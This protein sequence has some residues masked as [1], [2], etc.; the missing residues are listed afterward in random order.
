M[1]KLTIQR[2]T[3]TNSIPLHSTIEAASRFFNRLM[4][5]LANQD[6]TVTASAIDGK[7]T[8]FRA[9]KGDQWIVF[10][11]EEMAAPKPSYFRSGKLDGFS[12]EDDTQPIR[13]V[14]VE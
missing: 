4:P 6:Y 12:A 2:P 9:D 14:S 13:V 10:Q 3:H 11:V 1:I 7:V 8:S 5:V